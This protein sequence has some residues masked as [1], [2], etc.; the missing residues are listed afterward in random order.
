[1]QNQIFKNAELRG[2]ISPKKFH[3]IFLIF[4]QPN[5]WGKCTEMDITML[6]HP[7][8]KSDGKKIKHYL[9]H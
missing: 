4:F 2:L 1:M 7:L 9:S 6:L 5:T 8:L 3:Q